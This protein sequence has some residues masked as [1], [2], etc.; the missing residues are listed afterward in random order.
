M[1]GAIGPVLI[2]GGEGFLG[3]A[4]TDALL[5]AGET[6]VSF[7]LSPAPEDAGR[8]RLHH[9][10]GDIRKPEAPGGAGP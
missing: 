6:V 3:R 7:D 4:L 5:A 8:P 2:T 10:A 1:T 9:A